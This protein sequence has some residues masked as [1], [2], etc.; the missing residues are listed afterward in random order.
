MIEIN[1]IFKILPKDENKNTVIFLIL[2]LLITFLE[3]FSIALVFP[4][5][6]F[7]LS[8]NINEENFYYFIEDYVKDYSNEEL[9]LL[10]LFFLASVYVFK[11]VYLIY[12]HWW[13]HG[14]INRVQYKLEKKLLKIYLHQSFLEILKKNSAFKLRNIVN[15]TSRFA[16]FLISTMHLFIEIMILIGITFVIFFLQPYAAFY[17]LILIFFIVS[18]FY[19]FAKIKTIQWSKKRIFHSGLSMKTLMESLSSIKEIKVFKKENFF[20]E[21]FSLNNKKVLHFR[22]M[23]ST[24]NES[25][26]IILEAASVLAITVAIIVMFNGGEEKKEILA[27][28][29]IFAAAGLRLLPSTSRIISSI[30]EIKNN[31]PSMDLI[32]EE[33][34]LEKINSNN[35][36]TE[37]ITD[38]NHEI[39]FNNVSF[40]YSDEKKPVIKDLSFSLIKGTVNAIVGQSGSGK[41]TILNLILGFVEPN[42]G[43]LTIDGK[44]IANKTFSKNFFGYVSQEI[45]LLD[46]SVKFNI[47]FGDE[48]IDEE[49]L[50][51]SIKVAQLENFIKKLEHGIDTNIGEKGFSIS[52]GQRQR[53]ATTIYQNPKILILDEATSELDEENEDKIIN[54]LIKLYQD[55]TII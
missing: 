4:L 51:K 41:S 12:L 35:I 24:F 49:K 21:N 8:D 28:V 1:K 5:I 46:N 10:L 55:K 20:I 17:V 37:N 6:I 3:S 2:T 45:L 19:I 16:K 34:K 29:G 52:G 33:F 38:F 25:P 15:E 48:N 32:I 53:I 23:F 7:G 42:K 31:L 22:R 9:L 30:N 47:S 11:N 50:A 39:K 43:E 36:S 40:S 27:M 44:N 13:K 26:R 14:F 54:D 18:I